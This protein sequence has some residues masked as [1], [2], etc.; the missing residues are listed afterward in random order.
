MSARAEKRKKRSRDKL[1]VSRRSA[2]MSR[3]R[4]KNTRF[5][6]LFIQKLKK[7]SPLRFTTNDYSVR[8]TPDIVFPGSKVCVFLD[9]DFWYGW[10]YP[11]WKHRLKND[12]WRNKIADNRKRDIKNTKYLRRKGWKVLR[13]WEHQMR[14]SSENFARQVISVIKNR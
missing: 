7:A 12:F 14:P 4:S 5:E 3:I 2:L 1:S 13:F 11:R 8:G 10:Q 6:K 9:S